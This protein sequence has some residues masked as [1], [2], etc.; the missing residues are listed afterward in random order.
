MDQQPAQ[1][2][3]STLSVPTRCDSRSTMPLKPVRSQNSG[4]NCLELDLLRHDIKIE[5]V[6]RIYP[7]GPA[8]ELLVL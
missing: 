7:P 1:A 5:T 8:L 3:T 2:L 4:W 6:T